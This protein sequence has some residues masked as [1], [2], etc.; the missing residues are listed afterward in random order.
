MDIPTVQATDLP[1][2]SVEQMAEV[3]RIMIEEIGMTLL[4]MM[5]N[6]GRNIAELARS[7]LGGSLVGR[8]VAVL[9]G[10][11]H[12]GGG[13]LVAAR[14]LSNGG[15]AVDVILGADES[16]LKPTTALQLGILQKMEVPIRP[17]SAVTPG[18]YTLLID[19]LLGYSTK[20]APRGEIA[21][22]IA[23]AVRAGT[24]VL[25]L[26]LPSGLDPDTGRIRDPHI[27]A[28]AT[29][30]LAAPKA[31]LLV[32][33]AEPAVGDLYVGDIGVPASVYAKLRLTA[34]GAMFDRGPIVRVMREEPS[35]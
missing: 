3:D 5:E 27:S 25:A 34:P 14:H 2:V 28:S 9:A 35:S 19:A 23:A 22:L 6:A 1:V 10:P 7:M 31:G 30:T 20:G 12:N 18:T 24:T 32:P 29:L 4:Q 16:R 26:D 33:Q 13:G 15:A 11:G 21:T 8:Q 17:S